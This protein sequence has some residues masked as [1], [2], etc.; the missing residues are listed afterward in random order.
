[1]H[2]NGEG[3]INGRCDYSCEASWTAV[4]KQSA[5][6][7]FGCTARL[8]TPKPKRCFT[9]HSKSFQHR[10]FGIRGPAVKSYSPPRAQLS[11]RTR[12]LSEREFRNA[13]RSEA[14]SSLSFLP[15][16]SHAIVF[17]VS[18]KVFC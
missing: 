5:D 9:P 2:N 12:D 16:C 7:A 3:K 14:S 11:L 4:A 6:T 13:A 8:V 18:F 1:M 17:A 15:S 10:P